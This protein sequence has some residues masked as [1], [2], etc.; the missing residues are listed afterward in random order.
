MRKITTKTWLAKVSAILSHGA[1]LLHRISVLGFFNSKIKKCIF[2]VSIILLVFWL[3]LLICMFELL[4]FLCYKKQLEQR[5]MYYWRRKIKQILS[6]ESYHIICLFRR[7]SSRISLSKSSVSYIL[8]ENSLSEEKS[9]DNKNFMKL[10]TNQKLFITLTR[11]CYLK[12]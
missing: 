2:L 4:T 10:L 8:R 12:P 9:L 3:L 7:N 1:R 5:I 6:E 11:L